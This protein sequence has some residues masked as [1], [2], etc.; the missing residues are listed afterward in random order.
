M[1]GG[2]YTSSS[3]GCGGSNAFTFLGRQL[4]AALSHQQAIAYE[5]FVNVCWA[6][7]MHNIQRR[8]WIEVRRTKLAVHR[9][10]AKCSASTS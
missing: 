1:S 4:S 5:M 8:I 7:V 3:S 10:I 9:S 6:N 2:L